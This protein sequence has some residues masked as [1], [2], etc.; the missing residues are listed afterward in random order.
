MD[1]PTRFT[2]RRLGW[3]QA[4]HGDTYTRRMP[5]AEPVAGFDNFDEAE[6]HRRG[7]EHAARTGENPFRFGGAALFFQSSLDAPR[8]HDWLLDEGIEPP[9]E[10]LRHRDWREWW[11]AFAHTW[12]E[13]QLAHAWQGLD[14]VRFFDAIGEPADGPF[15]VLL[16]VQFAHRGAAYT[17]TAE[18]EGG[19]PV[20]VFRRFRTAAAECDR[21]NDPI[22]HAR[23]VGDEWEDLLRDLRR[24]VFFETVTIPGE[25]PA[26]AAVGYLVQRLA[27]DGSGHVCHDRTYRDTGSRVPV[28]VFADRAAA[29]AHRD[30]LS[31]AARE[32]MNPFQAYSPPMA[33][34]HDAEFLAA[35]EQ[36]RPP[37]PWP[38]HFSPGH[39]R[40]WWD[41]CQDE[42]TPEQR[43]AAWEMFSTH[44]L[45]EV[46]PVEVAD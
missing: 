7:L 11:D 4:P 18:R 16:E 40:E 28:R 22:R 42:L 5:S 39:W 21:R 23:P 14:K 17:S 43:H 15:H 25:L 1:N 35:V 37:L 13:A 6:E 30:E 29:N 33:G 27:F 10:E 31:A 8:L 19:I 9:A 2:V 3:H 12:T 32:V 36:L 20:R 38:T 34:L 41:L 24:A 46:L 45:F 44:P 26:H